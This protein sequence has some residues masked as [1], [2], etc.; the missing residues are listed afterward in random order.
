VARRDGA[1]VAVIQHKI[2][3]HFIVRQQVAR[4]NLL[5]SRM[6]AAKRELQQAVEALERYRDE[7]KALYAERD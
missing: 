3:P 7:T 5:H 6:I 1:R 4:R 2:S